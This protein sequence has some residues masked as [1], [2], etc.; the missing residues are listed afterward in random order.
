MN[1]SEICHLFFSE[2]RRDTT[3]NK[4]VFI[5]KNAVYSYGF[6]FQLGVEIEHKGKK[7]LFVNT[8]SYSNS[9]SKHQKHFRSAIN[10][11]YYE[12]VFYFDFVYKGGY[13]TR[14]CVFD[15]NQDYVHKL[16]D[17]ISQDAKNHLHDFLKAKIRLDSFHKFSSLSSFWID[18]SNDFP[19]FCSDK[20]FPELEQK[21]LNKIETLNKAQKTAQEKREQKREREREIARLKDTEK[22]ALWLNREYSGQLYNLEKVYLRI[23]SCGQKIETSKGVKV[24]LK[25]ALQLHR[26]L[27][28]GKAIG[29]YIDGFQVLSVTVDYIKIGCHVIYWNQINDFLNSNNLES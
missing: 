25:K 3:T 23:S 24:C 10:S 13:Y 5:H 4:N 26:L 19:E 11:T 27:L 1:H 15:L 2:K 28:Q 9:T 16:F 14:N 17:K 12:K 18:F 22:L 7:Y 21:H 29:S 6:H 20:H 8:R